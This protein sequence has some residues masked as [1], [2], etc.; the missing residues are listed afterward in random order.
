MFVQPN[1]T[2]DFSWQKLEKNCNNSIFG[3][4]KLGVKDELLEKE[5]EDFFRLYGKGEKQRFVF[6][7]N[8]WHETKFQREK[9]L[10]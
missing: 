7:N 6:T 5:T 8:P 9:N 10:V 2:K 1:Y 4:I 3:G